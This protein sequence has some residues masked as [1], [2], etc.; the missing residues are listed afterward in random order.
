MPLNFL[1]I[2]LTKQQI[3]VPAERTALQTLQ[4]LFGSETENDLCLLFGNG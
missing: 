3:R 1:S 2:H 4:P